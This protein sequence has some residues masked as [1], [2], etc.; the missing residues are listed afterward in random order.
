MRVSLVETDCRYT[1]P[2]LAS[3]FSHSVFPKSLSSLENECCRLYCCTVL[4][5]LDVVHL[6]TL[7]SRTKL[8]WDLPPVRL[9]TLDKKSSSSAGVPWL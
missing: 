9:T 6:N 5:G 1:V 2:F 3:L 4:A 7:S 8:Q